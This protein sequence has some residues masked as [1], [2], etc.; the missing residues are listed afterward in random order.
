[1]LLMDDNFSTIVNGV[2]EGTI[3]RQMFDVILVFS[4]STKENYTFLCFN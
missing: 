1:M 2:E 3:K 4:A